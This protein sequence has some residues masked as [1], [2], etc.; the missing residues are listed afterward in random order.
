MPPGSPRG[1]GGREEKAVRARRWRTMRAGLVPA[2][3]LLA[4][5]MAPAGNAP[6][7]RG[8]YWGEKTAALLRHF[9]NRAVKLPR[10]IDFGDSYA[11]VALPDAVIGGY[12]VVTF[13]QMDKRSHGL[14]RIQSEWPRHTVS[15]PAFRALL[16]ALTAAYGPPDAICAIRPAPTNGF[17]AGAEALWRRRGDSIRAIFRDTTIEAFAGCLDGMTAPCGLVGQ[18]LLRISPAGAGAARCPQAL[19]PAR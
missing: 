10:P 1:A 6:S 17:Q 11:E 3:L 5:P 12:P 15:P 19:P 2:L 16:R 13:F 7:W 4:A 8:I 9:G 18:L 14:K